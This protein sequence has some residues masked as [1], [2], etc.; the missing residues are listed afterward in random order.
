MN[1]ANQALSVDVM[2][3]KLLN[4]DII[5]CNSPKNRQRLY[6]RLKKEGIKFNREVI[7]D[8]GITTTLWRR[9]LSAFHIVKWIESQRITEEV[10]RKACDESG[11]EFEDFVILFDPKVSWDDKVELLEPLVEE[12]LRGYR[13][14][15][16]WCYSRK[17]IVRITLIK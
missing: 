3:Q 1:C 2:Y 17:T 16:D 14:V 10:F 13:N 15:I 6:K 5:E 11:V 9:R 4:G 12:R 8:T 7:G